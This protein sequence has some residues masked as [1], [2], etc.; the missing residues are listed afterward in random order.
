MNGWKKYW[1]TVTKD[2]LGKAI[3]NFKA[4]SHDPLKAYYHDPLKECLVAVSADRQ[5]EGFEEC[6]IRVLKFN[7]EYFTTSEEMGELIDLFC[8]R[9]YGTLRKMLPKRVYFY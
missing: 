7:G 3:E 6:A 2:D 8:E 1:L 4:Y 5:Y 9:K